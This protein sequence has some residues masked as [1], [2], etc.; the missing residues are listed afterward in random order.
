MKL[1]KQSP[2]TFEQSAVILLASTIIVKLI[3][4][5]FKIPLQRLIGTLGFGYFSSAYDLFLPIYALSMAGLP[6]AVSRIVAENV[7]AERY[8]EAKKTFSVAQK[9]FLVTGFTGLI[10]ILCAIFPYVKATTSDTQSAKYIALCI[11]AV[12]PSILFCCLMSS[13]RGYYEGMRNMLPTAISDIIEA[14]G[15]LVLGLGFAYTVLKL[16]GDVALAA[17]GALAGIMIG[18]VLS[19]LYLW[20]RQKIVGDP[21]SE[22]MLKSSPD[23]RSGKVVLSCLLTIAIPVALSS[24]ANNLTLIIDTFMIKLQLKNIMESSY[25]VIASMYA[26]AI[27]DYNATAKQLLS[28]DNMP[29]F[30]YGIRGEAYTLYNLIPTLTTT[31]GIGA[32]PVLTTAWVKNEKSAIKSNIEKILRT[33]AI[34]A[35]PAGI[36]VLSISPYLMDLLYGDV[37]SVEIGS[38]MLRILGVAAIFSGISVPI[39]SMLQAIGKPFVPL[40]NIAV[41]AVLKIIVNILLVGQP[42]INIIGAPVGTTVC[43]FYIFVSNMICLI[44]YSHIVPDFKSTLIKPLISGIGCGIAAFFVSKWLN[45]VGMSAVII[46]AVSIAVAVVVYFS[47]IFALKTL[48][49]EDVKDFPK[50]EKIAALLLKLRLIK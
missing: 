3:G 40:F 34:I 47:L 46:T 26:N 41:G 19:T 38:I 25:D 37:A 21:I 48:T 7:A 16:T 11:A 10:V 29:T 31:L 39:T 2:Q 22:N 32:I 45:A 44:K 17:A 24:L 18:T 28:A 5:V 13:F 14:L 9:A 35:I 36:G 15:K 8:K 12:A 20:L 30:L 23:S 33:T 50:G 4:A 6:I 42:R 27:A 1:K 49:E 43:Y